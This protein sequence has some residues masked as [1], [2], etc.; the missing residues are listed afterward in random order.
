MFIR[1]AK[2]QKGSKTYRYCQIVE[3]VRRPGEK[4]A[5]HRTVA[6]LGELSEVVVENLRRAFRAGARGEV[7]VFPDDVR[8]PGEVIA[9]LSWLDVGVGLHI[10]KQWQLNALLSEV[11]GG[12]GTTVPNADVVLALILHRCVAPGSKLSAQQWFS[13]TALPELLS[14]SPEQFNN[15]RIHRAL[16]ALEAVG[17]E[18]QRRLAERVIEE[19][20]RLTALFLDLTDTWFVGQGPDKA[21]E[22]KTKEGLW[23]RK[24]SIVLLCDEDGFPLRWNV[25]PGRRSD[26]TAMTD[27]AGQLRDVDWVRDLP[28]VCD[29]AMGHPRVVQ[30]LAQRGVR[31]VTMLNPRVF[32]A[33]GGE[34]VPYAL[35]EGLDEVEGATFERWCN[36]ADEAASAA[37]MA[38]A[39]DRLR[40][41]DLGV[42]ESLLKRRT[43][44]QEPEIAKKLVQAQEARRRN[45][46]G[47]SFESIAASFGVSASGLAVSRR[48][49]RL[50][51]PV[52]S[53]V[54][55]GEANAL[56]MSDLLRLA[57]FPEAEQPRQLE[58][59]LLTRAR[60]SEADADEEDADEDAD[61][62]AEAARAR[63][64]VVFNP[65]AFVRQRRNAERNRAKAEHQIAALNEALSSP[66]SQRKE[67][68]ARDA[69][70]RILR[71]LSLETAFEVHVHSRTTL[72]R[73]HPVI[74]L[75]RNNP[76]WNGLRRRD[77]F[78]MLV[79]HPDLTE[80]PD[81][82]LHHYASKNRIEEDFHVIKSIVDVR[83][84]F[85]RQDA[86]VDA[87]VTI[88]MLAL[89]VHRAIERG[90]DREAT[91]AKTLDALAS[92]QLVR[93]QAAGGPLVHQLVRASGDQ[94][95]LLSRLACSHLVEPE[96][97]PLTP[98]YPRD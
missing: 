12:G 90:L 72:G 39:R 82:L 73:E 87:H 93:S 44:R 98:V 50:S 8:A 30:R 16:E 74:E 6:N 33:F 83:P 25:I 17:P 27:M 34:D 55:S 18:L 76:V 68:A 56:L 32:D 88:C 94:K 91:G 85:H 65:A 49:L 71:T 78:S 95:A 89:L 10:C 84:V 70:V 46:A 20:T 77:G 92:V 54:A 38:R 14:I 79:A 21:E 47:E 11:L 52:Q 48:L 69:A 81:A 80:T 97:I 64:V 60:P 36:R 13:R 51:E 66:R 5:T 57:A 41:K 4:N 67:H 53:K 96:S 2:V 86:K 58:Q 35:T 31:F 19:K 3:S 37:G 22:R 42:R 7:L 29:R 15:A 1:V 26:C 43:V 63:V 23:R 59:V 24:V 40:I 45:G 61:D 9:A 28:V 62:D 75:V